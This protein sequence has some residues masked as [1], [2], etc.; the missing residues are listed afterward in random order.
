MKGHKIIN[1][2]VHGFINIDDELLL[3]IV[4]HSWIQRLRS[5]RQLG[6][7]NLVYPG[8]QHTRYAH[9]LG[10]MHLMETA[11]QTLTNKGVIIS[12]EEARACKAAMLMHDIGHGPFSHVLECTI[13]KDVSHEDISLILM[14]R[15]NKEF[16]GALQLAIDIFKGNNCKRFL[17]QLISSQLDTDR[18]DYLKRDS[19]YSGV[20]EGSIGSER[21]IKMLNVANDE[22]VVEAKGIYSIENF[23][24]ARRLMYWQVYLHKTVIVAERMLI[25]ILTRAKELAM[26]G[27]ELFASPALHYFLYNDINAESFKSDESI[28]KFTLLDDSDILTSV[29]TWISSNDQTLSHLSKAFTNRDLFKIEISRQPFAPHRI[30][31]L[32]EAISKKMNIAPDEMEYFLLSGQVSSKTYTVGYDRINIMFSPTYICDISEASDMLNLQALGNVDRRFYIC[33]PKEVDE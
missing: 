3:R 2:P 1:D 8:A 6:M 16:D 7:T 19:F 14:E 24:I 21:I 31:L 27:K 26:S 30:Q 10:A 23:L 22:L 20:I 11:I 18:M 9:A 12:E 32:K 29:K 25:K 4:D 15:M 13:V 17:H 33:Y 5:I 28:S